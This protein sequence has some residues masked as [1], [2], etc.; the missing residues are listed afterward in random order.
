MWQYQNLHKIAAGLLNVNTGGVVTVAVTT[1]R[2]SH[3][4]N[5]HLSCKTNSMMLKPLFHSIHQLH[6]CS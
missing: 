1:E 4:Q 6:N 3:I 5:Q 2:A